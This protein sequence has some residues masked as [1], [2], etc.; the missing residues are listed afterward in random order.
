MSESFEFRD[1]THFTAGAVG[2]PGAR[3]FYLQAGDEIHY[4]SVKLEKQQVDALATFLR[5]VMDD[6]PS[7][8][9]AEREVVSLI[10]PA[11]PEWVVGQIAVGIDEAEARVVLVVEELD[12]E[13]DDDDDEAEIDLF[14]DDRETAKLRVHLSVDQAAAFIATSESLMKKGRPPCRLCGQPESSGG[15]ACPRLN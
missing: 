3:V 5:S 10:E 6:L 7:P 4:V 2:E 8:S 13:E 1:V 14:L 11:L 12:I 15:H 9:T